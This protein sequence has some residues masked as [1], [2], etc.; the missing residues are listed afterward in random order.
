MTRSDLSFALF[1]T[2]LGACGIAWSAQG[3]AC[4]RLPEPSERRARARLTR[5]FPHAREAV[6][7]PH[8]VDAIEGIVALLNGHPS[9][10]NAVSL[11]MEDVPAFDRRVYEIA[12]TIP[13]GRVLTYGEIAA[14]LGEP[15]EARAVGQAL[16]HNP[17]AIV[18]P[19]HRVVAAGGKLGGFSAPGG[20]DTKLRLLAI[21]GAPHQLT[22]ELTTTS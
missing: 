19:C 20:V 17:F 9:D 5:R 21:E 8:V 3:I 16:G 22:M 2:T 12:R 14:R 11:D 13:P 18:V 7:P 15:R 6:P 1:E 4:T 10:L